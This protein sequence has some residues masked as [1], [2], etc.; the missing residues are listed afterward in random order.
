MNTFSSST[1]TGKFIVVEGPNGAGKST[2]IAGVADLLRSR[3]FDVVVTREPGGSPF[4]ES[5]RPI[6]KD[7]ARKTN[8]FATALAF[9]ACRS[10]HCEQTIAP[11]VARGAIVICDRYYISTEIYQLA[12]SKSLTENEAEFL[13]QLHR[14]FRQPDLTIFILPSR[15]LLNQRAKVDRGHDRFEG[16]ASELAA[17]E[18]YAHAF[19]QLRHTLTLRPDVGNESLAEGMEAVR[20][21]VSTESPEHNPTLTY[22]GGG[23]AVNSRG[24]YRE[25]PWAG[26]P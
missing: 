9:N 18:Q 4:A 11:A 10:D 2:F 3:G 7:P 23:Y 16:N 14:Q 22:V 12:L 5:I 21:F 20:D 25:A 17:Y 6:L 26:S 13:R 8:A 19:E 24:N 1:D 15:E